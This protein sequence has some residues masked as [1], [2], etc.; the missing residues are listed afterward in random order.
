[1][2]LFV[3]FPFFFI[4]CE[5]SLLINNGVGSIR[6][7]AKAVDRDVDYLVKLGI[8]SDDAEEIYGSSSQRL[9]IL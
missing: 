1:M 6:R 3:T 9:N 4:F 5:G 2:H 8:T 7:L